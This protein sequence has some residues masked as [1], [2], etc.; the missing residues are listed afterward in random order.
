MLI[1]HL[2][3]MQVSSCASTSVTFCS[4]FSSFHCMSGS[5]VP[6]NAHRVSKYQLRQRKRERQTDSRTESCK[7]LNASGSRHCESHMTTG[8]PSKA[9][10]SDKLLSPITDMQARTRWKCERR[11]ITLDLGRHIWGEGEG[12]G[13]NEDTSAP[14][15]RPSQH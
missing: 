13:Y 12:R 7:L 8:H 14:Y 4:L 9:S 1:M 2:P 3:A 10:T 11:H 6:A 15:H 5:S